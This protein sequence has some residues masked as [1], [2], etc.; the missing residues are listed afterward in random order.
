MKKAPKE[1]GII[2]SA[3]SV[4]AILSG[5]KTQ[6]RM[7]T[8]L[9]TEDIRV[10]GGDWL[11]GNGEIILCP[12][13][14]L[15]DRLWVREAMFVTQTSETFHYRTESMFDGEPFTGLMP[16]GISIKPEHRREVVRLR[17]QHGKQ[18][19]AHHR[20]AACYMPRWASRI[21]LEI[22][23]V[24]VERVQEIS[25]GDCI[26]E[27]CESHY[28]SPEDTASC[29]PGSVERALAERLEGGFLTAKLDFQC[30]WDSLNK[31]GFS[32]ESNPWVWVLEFKVVK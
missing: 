17:Q 15:G 11:A 24:R 1:R 23:G 3:E 2:F 12:Y 16:V 31:R 19:Y 30:R 6:T 32:W 4:R 20:I 21:T 22:T 9:Q 26:A 14:S 13:G 5:A 25:A 18:G 29:K 27:G 28:C 10:Q 8:K 7:V